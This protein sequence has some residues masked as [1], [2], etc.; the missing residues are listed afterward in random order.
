MFGNHEVKQHTFQTALS[1]LHLS[2]FSVPTF[3]SLIA[4]RLIFIVMN[5]MFILMNLM[6][7]V[8]LFQGSWCCNYKKHAN[9]V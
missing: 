4:R 9:T 7:I 2:G 6:F 8:I 1:C 3:V 5:L